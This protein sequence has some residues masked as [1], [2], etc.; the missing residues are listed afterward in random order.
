M[1]Q[2]LPGQAR[3]GIWQLQELVS[4]GDLLCDGSKHPSVTGAVAVQKLGV[5]GAVLDVA[6]VVRHLGHGGLCRHGGCVAAVG[7]GWCPAVA[8]GSSSSGGGG[9]SN[10]GGRHCWVQAHWVRP[11]KCPSHTFLNQ[12]AGST[13][14]RDGSW[15]S[16][17]CPVL[18]LPVD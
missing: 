3:W 14:G 10:P 17:E 11:P 9:S 13:G 5:G 12:P 7:N 16:S 18:C 4:Q 8:T 15:A 6:K 2:R 1:T